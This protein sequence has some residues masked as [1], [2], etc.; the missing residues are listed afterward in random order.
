MRSRGVQ[1]GCHE[2]WSDI[3]QAAIATA[4]IGLQRRESTPRP[5]LV[6]RAR[7]LAR[8]DH[9]R[10]LNA[11]L[12]RLDHTTRLVQ[13]H[14]LPHQRDHGGCRPFLP[15]GFSLGDIW[16]HRGLN[17]MAPGAWRRIRIRAR[18]PS[19][20]PCARAAAHKGQHPSPASK[21][22]LNVR[23][24][25]APT[26]ASISMKSSQVELSRSPVP[27]RDAGRARTKSAG[28]QEGFPFCGLAR[29]PM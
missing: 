4:R 12:G 23:D 9:P 29:H 14:G 5:E 10:Q 18:A 15:S 19:R 20:T 11:A 17:T 21:S 28:R 3:A 16:A 27:S 13:R 7:P 25:R 26:F 2:L 22:S 8:L 1:P 24:R 6:G